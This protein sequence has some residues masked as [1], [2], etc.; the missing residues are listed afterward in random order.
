MT[1]TT[2][3]AI[4]AAIIIWASAFVGIRAGLHGYSP[5][6]MA[7]LR[8]LVASLVMGVIYFN[9]P[10]RSKMR[11]A[12]KAGLMFVGI[13]GIGVY[14]L[15]LNYG[16]LAV[17]SG[18]ASFITS[19]SPV[20]TTVFAVLFLGERLTLLRISGFLV[21]LLGITIIAYGEL[22]KLELS[23]GLMYVFAAMVAGSCFS[24]MQKPYLK[25]YNAIEATT[26]VIWGGTLFLLL[27]VSK[28]QHDFMQAS[29]TSTLIVVYL[30]IFPATLAYIAWCYVLGRLTVSHAVSYLYIMPFVAALMG[31]L[32]LGEVPALLSTIGA[33]I[34]IGGVW[35]VSHSYKSHVV[36][37]PLISTEPAKA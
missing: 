9:T 37:A 12:D 29:L 31:W 6:G 17:S 20:V 18:V 8:Y 34:A 36:P 28:M 2:R 33:V 1:R 21:S 26:Y 23:A 30:G 10:Q 24:I 35:L 27:F 22:G 16:E 32:L 13:I 19:Q 3:A 4:A 25:K 11:M 5:E 15:T 7:L 14:N